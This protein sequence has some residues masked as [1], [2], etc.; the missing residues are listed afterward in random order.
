VPEEHLPICNCG[1]LIWRSGQS[2]KAG[3]DLSGLSGL[4]A[5]TSGP[6]L[7]NLVRP[8]SA[9]AVAQANQASRFAGQEWMS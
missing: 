5:T 9:L 2:G 6:P 7:N 4:P 1:A 3:D 8:M